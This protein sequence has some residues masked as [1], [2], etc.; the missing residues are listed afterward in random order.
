LRGPP[1]VVIVGVIVPVPVTAISW[2]VA[3][4]LAFDTFAEY[5]AAASGANRTNIVVEGTVPPVS[6][7]MTPE[8]KPDPDVV[9][10]SNPDGAVTTRFAERK[11]PLTVYDCSAEA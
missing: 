7:S 6:I 10:T 1:V 9:D 4:V 11:L 5:A 8:P 2:V 3:P